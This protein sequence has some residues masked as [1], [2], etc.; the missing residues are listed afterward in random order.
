MPLFAPAA[1]FEGLAELWNKLKP[2]KEQPP[3]PA[4]M[5]ALVDDGQEEEE[6]EQAAPPRKSRSR[7]EDL[8]RPCASLDAASLA[9]GGAL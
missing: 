9:W 7:S 5:A 4:P 2:G 1:S 6:E 8:R 3:A